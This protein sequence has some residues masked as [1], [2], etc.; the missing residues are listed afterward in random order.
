M[1]FANI[2]GGEPFVR[3]DLPEIVGVLRGKAKRL[4]VITNGYFTDRVVSLCRRFPDI[5]VRIS[6]EG[7]PKAND[8]IRGIPD[9]FDRGL[10]T[11][12]ELRAMGLKDI[13]FSTTVQDLN[14]ADVVPLY[15]L[16]G[17]LGYEFATA[18]VH[19]SHYFHKWDNKIGDKEKVCGELE[20]LVGELLR[21]DRAK[22]W[23]RAYFNYGL[24]NY[25]R[26]NPRLLPCEMGSNGFFLDPWGDVLVCNGMDEKRPIGNL[27]EEGWDDIWRGRRAKEA[28]DAVRNCGK[29]CWMIGSAAP[30]M[31][32]HPVKPV[33]WV[34][35]NKFFKKGIRGFKG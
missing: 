11:L 16:A 1:F 30:A 22:D 10:R 32:H 19:N 2:T 31:W 33:L 34:L 6:I 9:G 7:L 28:R 35:R 26:G 20:R 15:R 27:K 21:S 25:I 3:E 13:G 29:N 14:C 12:L 24:V 17:A 4:V 5:G 18:A 23:F 8:A